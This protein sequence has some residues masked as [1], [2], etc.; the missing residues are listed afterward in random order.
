MKKIE[1]DRIQFW[2]PQG[3]SL[4]SL[5][6]LSRSYS[7]KQGVPTVGESLHE[8]TECEIFASKPQLTY[9]NTNFRKKKKRKNKNKNRN[10]KNKK[11][12]K[13]GGPITDNLNL[14]N[15]VNLG[16]LLMFLVDIFGLWRSSSFL[17]SS[18]WVLCGLPFRPPNFSLEFIRVQGV[19][20][21]FGSLICLWSSC[22]CLSV[23]PLLCFLFRH[24]GRDCVGMSWSF[25][26]PRLEF[27]LGI[28]S[29]GVRWRGEYISFIDKFLFNCF[30]GC[31][32]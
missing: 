30:T 22:F 7:E 32:L 5:S 11:G 12:K 2:R 25:I 13:E 1:S 10:R 3:H 16:L 8:F 26:F 18:W 24:V 17:F 31:L 15:L 23:L 27:F 29:M 21:R 6:S 14:D 20:S 19:V 9:S 4:F 28:L